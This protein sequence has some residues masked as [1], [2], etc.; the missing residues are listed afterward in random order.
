MNIGRFREYCSKN[1]SIE[2]CENKVRDP[3]KRPVIPAGD[4]FRLVLEM[5]ALGQK[6]LLAVDEDARSPAFRRSYGCT[7]EIVASDTSIERVL[8]GL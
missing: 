4:V 1:F 5:P 6:S 8:R 7:R 3:R 2:A